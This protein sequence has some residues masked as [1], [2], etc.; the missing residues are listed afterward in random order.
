MPKTNNKK[1]KPL[2]PRIMMIIVLVLG[3]GGIGT[4]LYVR[5]NLEPV[6]NGEET[7]SFEITE[8][9][10]FDSVLQALQ[11]QHL[12]RSDTIAK[13][14]ARFSGV[15]QYYAGLFELND[16]M[17]TSE[18]LSYIGNQ[19]NVA[20]EEKRLT[21][22]EGT[23]AK[24]IA[25]S[26]SELYPSYSTEDILSLWNDSEYIQTL[27]KD[28][29]F[30]D[31]DTLNNDNYKVK[32]EGYLFPETYFLSEDMDLDAITRMMLDQFNVVYEEHKSE[33]EKSSYS[34]NELVTLASVVQFESGSKQDMA[35]I[36]GVFYNR[37]N[38]DMRLES[39]VTVCYALYD[40][41][42]DPQDCETQTDVDSPY[43]TYLHNGLPIGPILNPGEDAIVA[44][45]NPVSS[46][47]LFFAADIH[48]DGTVYYSKTYEEHQRICEELGL[49]LN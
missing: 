13:L 36:A 21:V 5:M 23:W 7:V 37:L 25:A 26:I 45:L 24:E 31:A 32:L 3:I 18:I 20:L 30:L 17:S 14:Y 34:V 16:G 44:T 40:Q 41:F 49:I 1:R 15:N 11:D 38:Q 35:S 12:I 8:G 6:G 27:A 22:P 33:F 39:S 2:W 46:D 19:D 9:E 4:F 10:S 47:Y 28:Y 29:D 48:G 42:D 43:N